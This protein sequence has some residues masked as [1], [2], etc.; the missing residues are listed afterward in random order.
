MLKRKAVSAPV[1]I[2]S[3]LSKRRGSTLPKE[4]KEKDVIMDEADINNNREG[5]SVHKSVKKNL[6]RAASSSATIAAT[7]STTPN[8]STTPKTKRK[9]KVPL[10]ELDVP[11]GRRHVAYRARG[12]RW[13]GCHVSATGGVQHAVI[14]AL[15]CGANSFALFL[16]SQRQWASKPLEQTDIDMF[17]LLCAKYGYGPNHI[18]PH[19]YVHFL[20]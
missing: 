1:S 20:F 19:G 14:N 2:G 6:R 4:E 8:T 15:Q 16:K 18:L 17:K 11:V 7:T 13:V 12:Q 3:N 9:K 5:E 10:D